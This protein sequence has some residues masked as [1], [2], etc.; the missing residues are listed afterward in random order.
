MAVLNADAVELKE[1]DD[2]RRHK[3]RSEARSEE[4]GV[5]WEKVGCREG[6][7]EGMEQG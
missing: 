7:E 6:S 1:A 4:T 5:G 2:Q 3:P